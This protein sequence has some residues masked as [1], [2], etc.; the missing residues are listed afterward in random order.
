LTRAKTSARRRIRSRRAV[1]LEQAPLR[2]GIEPLDGV[3]KPGE[4][5][6]APSSLSTNLSA[7]R[8]G[9][10]QCFPQGSAAGPP[11]T[12]RAR[13]AGRGRRRRRRVPAR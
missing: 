12:P 8:R 1:A 10:D 2:P 4:P 5:A 9:V 7:C 6:G 3:V 11:A 13:R